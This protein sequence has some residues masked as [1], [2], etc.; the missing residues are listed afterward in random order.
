MD[1]FF[2]VAKEVRVH[3]ADNKHGTGA[4]FGILLLWIEIS[5]KCSLNSS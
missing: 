1:E 3:T 4:V 5:D 2:P